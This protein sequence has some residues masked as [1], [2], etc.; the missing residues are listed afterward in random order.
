MTAR[1][2]RGLQI[3]M[4][5]SVW[6]C[7]RMPTGGSLQPP[8]PDRSTGVCLRFRWGFHCA[9]SIVALRVLALLLHDVWPVDVE[10]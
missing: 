8:G 4:A 2:A 5:L 9:C 1:N 7:P 10:L 3:Q 6:L